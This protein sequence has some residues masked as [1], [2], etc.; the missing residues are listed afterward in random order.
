MPLRICAVGTLVPASA[1]L[2]VCLVAFAFIDNAD[3]INSLVVVFM[4]D[5]HVRCTCLSCVHGDSRTRGASHDH[6]MSP[7][8]GTPLESVCLRQCY[9]IRISRAYGHDHNA[10]IVDVFLAVPG[11]M[12]PRPLTTQLLSSA[13]RRKCRWG[14]KA[15]LRR[16]V[17]VNALRH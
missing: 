17:G 1:D 2:Q 3:A 16:T 10:I 11:Q 9:H 8:G 6:Q 5:W 14:C 13:A 15:S 7:W 4:V 12:L